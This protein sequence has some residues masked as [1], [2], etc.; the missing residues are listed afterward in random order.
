MSDAATQDQGAA[1][2]S[3]AEILDSLT[4]MFDAEMLPDEP[5]KEQTA[6]D[7][8]PTVSDADDG[9]TEEEPIADQDTDESE[10]TDELDDEPGDEDDPSEEAESS[11]DDKWMP[12]SLDELAEALET[13]PE[14][15]TTVLK[16]KTKVDGQ[17]GEATLK[18][19]IKSYQLEKTLNGRLEAH[20]N[21]RKT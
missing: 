5:D 4:A 12:K 3:N 9:D 13:S 21:E 6:E 10:A 15:L 8:E 1:G 16:V 17:E 18:D 14:D 19:V 7:V 20:A 11:D 2:M